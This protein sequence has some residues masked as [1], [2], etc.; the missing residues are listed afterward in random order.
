MA[1]RRFLLIERKNLVK[2]HE[3][4][5]KASKI[6]FKHHSVFRQNGEL[7]TKSITVGG[8]NDYLAVKLLH[9]YRGDVK[10]GAD[11]EIILIKIHS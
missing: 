9:A 5:I 6:L 10:V 4:L 2:G 8:F 7:E 3:A 1:V 11:H